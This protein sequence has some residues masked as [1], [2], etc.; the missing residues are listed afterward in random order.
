VAAV[1]AD[2]KTLPLDQ[3]GSACT[4]DVGDAIAAA[5]SRCQ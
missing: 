5:V 4:R 3:G 1:L 2:G